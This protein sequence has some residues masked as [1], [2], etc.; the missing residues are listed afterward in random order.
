M[1]LFMKG[2]TWIDREGRGERKHEELRKCFAEPHGHSVALFE[3]LSVLISC[4]C[5]L[6]VP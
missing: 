5:R 6:I 1:Y 2:I 3:I 4:S